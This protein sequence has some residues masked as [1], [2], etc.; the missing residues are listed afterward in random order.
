[1]DPQLSTN[2]KNRILATIPQMRIAVTSLDILQKDQWLAKL[3]ELKLVSVVVLHNNGHIHSVIHGKQ[4][5]NE[6]LSSAEGLSTFQ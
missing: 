5:E 2:Q 1:M 3:A 4:R 6:L